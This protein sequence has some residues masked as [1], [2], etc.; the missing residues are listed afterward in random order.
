MPT[1]TA[2]EAY[3]E[4]FDGYKPGRDQPT[5]RMQ[6]GARAFKLAVE[7]GVTIGLG[8]DVGVFTHGTNYR[9]LEWMVRDGMTPLQALLAATSVSAGIIGMK[10]LGKVR[11][12][13]Q[14]D[15]I[16]VPGDPTANIEA[17]RNVR[18]VMKGGV[19]YKQP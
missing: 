15:L 5:A 6:Q 13:F 14:A 3:A 18:F 4:Y 12:K 17:V 11:P 7:S 2:I 10:D 1:L 8:S 16:A 19:I 9:E